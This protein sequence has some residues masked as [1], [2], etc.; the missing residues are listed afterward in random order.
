MDV[1]WEVINGKTIAYVSKEKPDSFDSIITETDYDQLRPSYGSAGSTKDCSL[2]PS[3]T[4]VRIKQ[5]GRS[6]MPDEPIS[7]RVTFSSIEKPLIKK[8][9]SSSPYK[10][11]IYRK[12]HLKISQT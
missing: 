1:S 4:P 2:R 8:S 7:N 11:I 10:F 5:K 12:I 6:S 3:Y 9:V